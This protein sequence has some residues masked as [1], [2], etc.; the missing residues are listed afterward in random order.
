L[1]QLLLG[2]QHIGDPGADHPIV[3]DFRA[4][5][6]NV[7]E[8]QQK[9]PQALAELRPAL[10]VFEKSLGPEAP[11]TA[12]LRVSVACLQLRLGEDVDHA[13]TALERGLATLEKGD[14]VAH[15]ASAQFAAAQ[16]LVTRDHARAVELAQRART[17]LA[18]AGTDPAARESIADIDRWLSAH[19]RQ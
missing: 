7:L 8:A 17:L 2:L 5:I 6:S 18:G 11:Y 4:G 12:W 14:D 19:L 15:R 10:A 13:M 3:A 1:W 16:A 9:L